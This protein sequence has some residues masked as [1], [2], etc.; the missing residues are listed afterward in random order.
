MAI[1]LQG[2]LYIMLRMEALD[3]AVRDLKI[4][5]QQRAD[6]LIFM[7][8]KKEFLKHGEQLRD[9]QFERLDELGYGNGGVVLKVKHIPSSIIMARKVS[10]HTYPVTEVM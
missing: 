8:E 2:T 7:N 10:R 6:L 3:K 1:L 4:T 9:S 5:D